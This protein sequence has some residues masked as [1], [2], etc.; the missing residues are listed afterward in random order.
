[1]PTITKLPGNVGGVQ[2]SSGDYHLAAIGDD[3]RVYTWGDGNL[4]QLGRGEFDFCPTPKP[5]EGLLASEKVRQVV[6]GPAYTAAV[7]SNGFV[8]T[9]G[10]GAA[11]KWNTQ[12]ESVPI[13]SGVLKGKSAV[14]LAC[15][16]ISMCALVTQRHTPDKRLTGWIPDEEIKFCMSCKEPFGAMRRR[17]HCRKCEGVFCSYCSMYRAP[18]LS[19]GFAKPVRVC[20]DCFSSLTK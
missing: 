19:K 1:M 17:H 18:I 2:I 5:V 14:R 15:G 13:L 20:L 10:Y 9:F 12:E 16:P 11:G 6:C 7:T 3:E 8:Y 4:G